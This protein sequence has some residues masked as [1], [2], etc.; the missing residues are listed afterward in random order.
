MVK[1]CFLLRQPYQAYGIHKQYG[2]ALEKEL[3]GSYQYGHPVIA[4]TTIKNPD[5]PIEVLYGGQLTSGPA[6]AQNPSYPLNPT[7]NVT[8]NAKSQNFVPP[9]N[10]PTYIPYAALKQPEILFSK[11]YLEDP[12]V[13]VAHAK[14]M[15]IEENT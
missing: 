9:V 6:T 7:R 4:D 3:Q 1:S 13:K 8:G 5:N 14:H 15:P 10:E 2:S 12:Q 11:E